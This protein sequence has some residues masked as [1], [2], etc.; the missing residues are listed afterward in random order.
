[1]VIDNN[2]ENPKNEIELV[3]EEDNSK[4][5]L[6]KKSLKV[7]FIFN[8]IS[9]ILN[10]ILPLITAPYIARVLLEEGIGQFS[11]A[12]SIIT[13]FTLPFSISCTAREPLR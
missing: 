6:P 8:F 4:S 5:V 3:N 2:D 9:Q 7:N 1:M 12:F 13:Y 10:L 11:Y